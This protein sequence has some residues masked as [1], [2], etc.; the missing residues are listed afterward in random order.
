MPPKRQKTAHAPPPSGAASGSPPPADLSILHP[1]VFSDAT[2]ARRASAYAS[3]PPYPH[4]VVSPLCDDARLRAVQLEMRENLTATFKET[5]LFKVLQTGDLVTI[6]ALD[7]SVAPKIPELLALRAAFYSPE[8]RAMVQKMTGCA[9][10]TDRVDCSAN[11]YPRSGHLLCHDDVI[12]TRCVS[13]IVYLTD[14]DDPWTARDG[15]ALEL[16]PV[17]APGTP[18][19][20][21]SAELLPAWNSMAFFTVA[22]GRSF[23]SV[24]EVFAEDKPRLSISGWYHAAEPP[25]GDHRASTLAQLRG[26]RGTSGGAEEEGGFEFFD[27]D[28]ADF[29]PFP[30]A[31]AAVMRAAAKASEETERKPEE[32]E[33]DAGLSGAAG[34]GPGPGGIVS[35]IVSGG[36]GSDSEDAEPL[37]PDAA[38][39]AYL[40]RFV[41]AEYLDPANVAQIREK[42]EEDSSV[43]MREFLKPEAAARLR[44]VARR[45]DANAGLGDG[46]VPRRT[47]GVGGG[48]R[49]VGPT[50]KQRYAAYDGAG[51]PEGVSIAAEGGVDDDDP[52]GKGVERDPWGDDADVSADVSA[53]AALRE[54]KETL[55]ASEPFARLLTALTGLRPTAHKGEIRRFRPGLDYTVAHRGCLTTDPRLDATL[56]LVDDDG[57]LNS[58]AWDFGEVGGFECYIAAD[59]TGAAGDAA[60]DEVYDAAGNEEEEDE[61][62]SVSA[63]H[64]TLSLVHRDEGLMRFVKY[65]SHLAP[66]SRW[67]VA[68]QYTVEDVEDSDEEEEEEEEEEEGEDGGE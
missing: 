45:E 12:G 32:E 26:A 66:S 37:G 50:H 46:K 27:D 2:V 59:E 39:L 54:V 15:G 6:D 58:S 43:Q 11:V 1:D 34:P 40:A 25:A 63:T 68:M 49:V 61:L 20:D 53:G 18:A 31:V 41:N 64:N 44:F 9:P 36:A 24:Q 23:H 67:D 3:A 47:A 62:L 10:L 56:C 65:V 5:D 52:K 38:D 60:T 16:Y 33:E 17:D 13:Y 22:P 42:M 4:G 14:P 48:W 51:L 29:V 30:S 57:D 8:F 55:L 7:P 21:P 28:I 35:G 19:T